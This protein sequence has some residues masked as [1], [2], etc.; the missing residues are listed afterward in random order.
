MTDRSLREV[1]RAAVAD[2]SPD[3][4]PDFDDVARAFAADPAAARRAR[5]GRS[6]PMANAY[7]QATEY[8]GMV[9]LAVAS[10][11]GKDAVLAGGRRGITGLR[12]RW[13]KPAVDVHAELPAVDEQG[14]AEL[15]RRLT[16]LARAHDVEPEQADRLA[17]ALVRAWPRRG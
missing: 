9:L 1:V 15:H 11:I 5:R 14:E 7:T 16:E 2:V 4:L 17:S 10:D 13:S 8:L 3:E 6:E 12:R